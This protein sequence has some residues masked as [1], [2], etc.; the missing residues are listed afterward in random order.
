LKGEQL[1]IVSG[2]LGVITSSRSRSAFV[3]ATD[4]KTFLEQRM[5]V[6]C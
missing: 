3:N 5:E 6:S 1:E 2:S 4:Q